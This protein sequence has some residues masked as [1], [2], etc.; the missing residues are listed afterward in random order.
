MKYV[1]CMSENVDLF[2][3][4]MT[5]LHEEMCIFFEEKCICTASPSSRTKCVCSGC[6]YIVSVG[7]RMNHESHQCRRIHIAI[8][9]FYSL[10]LI[11]GHRFILKQFEI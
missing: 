2:V 10:L 9:V 7:V 11:L 4:V 1:D 8:L 5:H 6:S 3:I